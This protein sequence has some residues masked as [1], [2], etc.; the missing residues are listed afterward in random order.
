MN[1]NKF[2]K[3]K[4]IAQMV[5][6]M[7]QSKLKRTLGSVQL[8]LLGIGAII[9]AG[10]FVLT[11]AAA[12]QAAGPA[13][14]LSF[15]LGGV[16]C[17]C[18]GLCYAEL[19]STIP[20]SGGAY[21]YM[22]A[23][24][25]E[26]IAWV[27]AFIMIVGNIFIIS[28]VAN[29][30]S[31]YMVSLL[32][33]VGIYLPEIFAHTTGTI[34]ENL[35]GTT[36]VALFNLPAAL[37]VVG[38]LMILYR[39]VEASALFNAISVFIKMGVLISFI[40]V[41]IFY[42]DFAN[43]SPFIPENTGTFGQFGISG[44]ASGAA[45]VFTA[46]NGFDAVANASNEAKNPQKSIPIGMIGALFI[47]ILT[48]VLCAAVLTGIVNY[49]D[50][51]VSQ[52]IALAVS[53]MGL[54]WFALIIKIGAV[55]G[56]S[57]VILVMTYSVVRVLYMVTEDGLLPKALAKLHRKH[58]TP[59]VATILISMIIICITATIPLGDLAQLGNC[60]VISVFAAVCI[61]TIYLRYKEPKLERTFR[62]PGM[63]VVPLIALALL[64]QTLLSMPDHTIY[65]YFAMTVGFA[66]V[67]YLT[68]AKYRSRA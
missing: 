55:A 20:S 26:I 44:I 58:H 43:W 39:G 49:K 15:V 47:C 17:A 2:F 63:P 33:D 50:L 54:S 41:G 56:L 37:I 67:T 27:I 14:M 45:M 3:R 46:Y 16:A 52:P 21:S 9:G 38:V 65:V 22:Y 57:S 40:L 24:F 53:K 7:N 19:S 32:Q 28:A 59:H 60:C 29:G 36:S 30:W 61:G 5:E 11:G 31:G 51:N 12:S 13:V 35:D 34:I 62:C 66:I 48:Y 10:I 4:S 42:I 23:I 64:L 25:G 18:T 68:F 1:L 6:E 8:I